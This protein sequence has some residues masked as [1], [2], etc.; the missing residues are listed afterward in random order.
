MNQSTPF[1]EIR[2][3][4]E[5]LRACGWREALETHP[6]R[7]F[8]GYSTALFAAAREAAE[9]GDVEREHALVTL[10]AVCS[11]YSDEN[12]SAEPLK[13]MIVTSSG[14]SPALADFEDQHLAP[15]AEALCEFDDLPLRAR[16]AD[17]LWTRRR[18]HAAARIGSTD[19]LE[20]AKNAMDPEHWVQGYQALRRAA[21]LATSLGKSSLERDAVATYALS[22]V[23]EI[24]GTDPLYLTMR[25]VQL[26]REN[27]LAAPKDLFPYLE[28]SATNA[29]VRKD[30]M[31]ASEYWGAAS[32]L[33]ERSSDKEGAQEALRRAGRAQV[34]AGE[35]ISGNIGLASEHWLERGYQ[36]LRQ[37]Q[38]PKEELVRLQQRLHEL[39]KERSKCLPTIETKVE[40]PEALVRAL[41][42]V[43]GQSLD[44]A[45][46][47]WTFWVHVIPKVKLREM[48]EE[49]RTK[50]LLGSLFG[51]NKLSESGKTEILIPPLP[52]EGDAEPDPAIVDLHMWHQADFLLQSSSWYVDYVRRIIAE[53]HKV[54]EA[55][56]DSLLRDNPLVEAGRE[57]I[58]AKGLK[59]AI[60]G[61]Y[62]VATHLLV[63]QIE[64][65]V[66]HLLGQHGVPTTFMRQDGTQEEYPLTKLVDLEEFVKIFGEDLAFFMRGLLAHK[67]GSNLRNRVAHGLMSEGAFYSPASI[68]I[69]PLVLRLL[70]ACKTIQ[71]R[72]DADGSTAEPAA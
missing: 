11:M 54:E 41:D 21:H 17:V 7:S 58:F 50:Y 67:A 1:S 9:T 38:A 16:I 37:G 60:E 23:R 6:D 18:D 15:L 63:P 55:S 22:L 8:H 49:Q 14:R 34:Q 53:E 27:G 4:A 62:L 56:F 51:I 59:L 43:R 10:A 42:L 44:E 19:Y 70:I 40:I 20:M 29:E 26:L 57:A 33:R 3:T 64:N 72:L 32:N 46:G 12:D 36:S 28:A 30:W 2:P 13:P 25:L 61:E 47:T 48:V 45:F 52:F 65:S 39:Q 66:R 68:V 69:A 71:K 31:R 24:D 5:G 35:E